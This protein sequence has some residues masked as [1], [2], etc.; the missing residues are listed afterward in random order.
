MRTLTLFLAA[1]LIAPPALA[2]DNPF[3]PSLTPWGGQG[4]VMVPADTPV[5]EAQIAA[6][7]DEWDR[8]AWVRD[9][10]GFPRIDSQDV[11]QLGMVDEAV[12]AL[13][14][15][16]Y[17]S[18]DLPDYLVGI[19]GS[20]AARTYDLDVLQAV[21]RFQLRHD[22]SPTGE[23]GPET[24]AVLNKPVDERLAML[25]TSIEAWHALST[26]LNEA[27]ALL[28]LPDGE[29]RVFDG[30]NQRANLRFTVLRDD[31]PALLPATPVSPA[32]WLSSVPAN[33]ETTGIRWQSGEGGSVDI[34]L[35]APS[36][37]VDALAI[38]AGD[39]TSP[40]PTLAPL[41]VAYLVSFTTWS[42]NGIV[43][44]LDGTGAHVAPSQRRPN[45]P[46]L[47][48]VL[49]ISALEGTH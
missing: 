28:N 22:L 43:R 15:S 25:K 21:Q 26:E 3:Q 39:T 10:G 32:G 46:E 31:R 40:S 24:L 27:F 48:A 42:E 45:P 37:A 16:L 18:N 8:L 2:S 30:A 20:F 13:R 14:A 1:L 29:L 33:A 36:L 44:Y 47:L 11:L 35:D 19:P 12:E 4:E 41:P 38:T 23:V 5:P 7:R 9:N 34:A 6:L 49:E 17:L